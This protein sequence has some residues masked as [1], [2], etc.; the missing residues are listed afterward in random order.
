[1]SFL[2]AYGQVRGELHE[3]GLTTMAILVILLLGHSVL[4][5]ACDQV[6]RA[7]TG[8]FTSPGYPGNY[9]NEITCNYTIEVA[10]NHV[11]QLTF[12]TFILE[13]P[14]WCPYD[15][16]EIYDDTT[17]LGTFCGSDGPGA[18]TS[19]SNR[20]TVVLKTDVIVVYQGFSANYVA[21][22]PFSDCGGKLS[23][24]HGQIVS[25][26]YPGQFPDGCV[27]VW[28]ITGRVGDKIRVTFSHLDL[29]DATQCQRDSLEFRDGVQRTDTLLN[30][31][32]GTYAPP[33][34]T[35]T[36]N[37]MY[38]RFVSG[39][40]NSRTGF[41]LTWTSACLETF[42]S[43][44]GIIQSPA[45]TGGSRECVFII[46]QRSGYFVQLEFLGFH[47]GSDGDH[48]KKAFIEVRDG[49]FKGSPL[50]GQRYC[51]NKLPPVHVLPSSQNMMWIR[52]VTDG[53]DPKTGFRANYTR[54]RITCDR[55]V[56]RADRGTFTSPLYP[57][58]Y[59]DLMNCSWEI[60]AEP[61]HV[62]ELTF[63]T[64]MLEGP[65]RCPYDWVEIHDGAT[66][67]GKFCG[68]TGPNVVKSSS[69]TVTVTFRTDSSI[70]DKGFTA[71]YI[72][73][74]PFSDELTSQ[75]ELY[76]YGEDKGDNKVFVKADKARRLLLKA[77]FPVG[78]KLY[79]KLFIANRGLVSFGK[80]DY[81]KQFK[82]KKSRPMIC[83]YNTDISEPG[84]N[85][86][87]YFQLY[88]KDGEVQ[89]K[90]SSQI[91][92]FTEHKEYSSSLV[93]VVTWDHVTHVDSPNPASEQAT[94]QLALISDG[95]RSYGVVYYKRGEMNWADLRNRPLIIGFSDGQEDHEPVYSPYC[96][97]P[98]AF[99][100][101]DKIKGNTGR[102][103]M[104]LHTIGDRFSP[105]QHCSDWK[106]RNSAKKKDRLVGFSRLPD[107]PCN[108]RFLWGNWRFS[109]SRDGNNVRCFRMTVGKSRQLAPHGKECCY[110]WDWWQWSSFGQFISDPPH[111]GSATAFNPAFWSLQ[112]DY[113]REDRQ[114]H[115]VCC[116][117]TTS[118][119]YCNAFY[120]LRPVGQCSSRIPFSF[121]WTWGDP[122]IK[123]LDGG[124][125]TF[126]G[127]GEYTMITLTS[128][129]LTFTLQ[130]R[131]G[132]AETES[133]SIT[134][135]TVFT[136]FG[137]EDNGV[138]VFVGLDPN[139]NE[140]LIIYGNNSDYST[141][142][143]D[144]GDDEILVESETYTMKRSN[145]SFV[146]IFASDIQLTISIGFKSL[147]ISTGIPLQY[148]NQT[149]GL[150]GNFNGVKDDDFVLPNGTF[151]KSNLTDRE[152]Y[153]DFG[154]SWAVTADNSILR[155][156]PREGPADFAHP[157]FIPIFLDEVAMDTRQAAED[158]CGQT[159]VACIYDYVA[160][161]SAAIANASK[162]TAEMAEEREKITENTIPVLTFNG[163]MYGTSGNT[164]NFN[165]EGY[166]PDDND[167]L[168]YYV[169]DDGSGAAQINSSSGDVTL[170]VDSS[171][172]VNMRFYAV[173]SKN[174]QSPVRD[175]TLITCSGCTNH[176]TCDF[177]RTST[178][179]VTGF[180]IAA[181]DCDPAWTG[182]NCDEDYDAC[183]ESPCD[184][185]QVCTDLTPDQQGGSDVGFT[186]SGCPDG[187]HTDPEDS[188]RCIDINECSQN[189]NCTHLCVNTPGSYTC[190]CRYGYRLDS[191]D[192][193]CDDVNECAEEM[194]GCQQQCANTEGSFECLCSPGYTLSSKGS[195]EANSTIRDLC[196]SAGCDHGCTPTTDSSGSSV[197]HCFCFNGYTLDPAN[198][199]SCVDRDECSEGV[200]S[201]SCTNTQGSFACTCYTGHV[202]SSD[203]RT[204]NPCPKLRYGPECRHTCECS[205]RGLSCHPVT[206]CVCQSGWTGSQCQDDVNEC[207]ESPD[208]CGEGKR[209]VNNNGSYTCL[210][211]DG[212]T[213]NSEGVCQDVDECSEKSTLNTCEELEQ[214]HN[215]PGS[216][217]CTCIHGYTRVNGT[218]TDLDE[219]GSTSQNQCQ[220][221]CSNVPGSYTCQCRYGYRLN[222]DRASCSQVKDVCAEFEGL[223][224]DHGCSLDDGDRAFCFCRTGYVLGT[225]KESCQDE[226]E[227]ILGTS[228]CSADS[229]CINT[230]GGYACR[231][232]I[233]SKLD[234]D[235]L[236]CLPCPTGTYGE[237]CTKSCACGL[238]ASRCDVTTG[239]V[240]KS[241][242]TGERCGQD[243]NE[244]DTVQTQEECLAKNAFCVNSQ[245]GY[246]CRCA[247]GYENVGNGCQDVNE[248]ENSPCE[249]QCEN[250]PCEQQCENSPCEQQCENF[251]GS[252]RCLCYEGFSFNDT[253]GTC[254]DIDECAV[255]VTNG[256]TQRCDNT[257]G[258]Y[259]CSCNVIGY[260]LESDNVTCNASTAL[261]NR[262]DCPTEN[263]GCSEEK[264]FCNNGYQL[265]DNNT[266]E[267]MDEDLCAVMGGECEQNC[268]ESSD[269]TSIVCGC[270]DGYLLNSDQQ[271]CRECP[272][273]MYGL[274]CTQE[275]TCTSNAESCNNVDGACL[276]KAGWEGTRCES[277][278]NECVTNQHNCSDDHVICINQ[279]GGYMCGCDI[280]YTSNES[281]SCIEC[282]ANMYGTNCTQECNCTINAESCNNVDGAC[283]CKA[284][285]EGTCCESDVNECLTNQ[286]NCSDDNVIC[287][288]EVGGYSCG[289]D[290]GYTSNESQNCI[291]CLANTYGRNCTQECTC[292]S[293]AES[294]NNVDGAC[295]C[296]AGWEGT[297]CESDV[298]ECLTNHN[299][300]FDDHMICINQDGGYKCGCEIG[301]TSNDSQS[302]IECPAN[303]YGPNCTQECTCT[304]NAESCNN[305]D[306]ACVCKAG[307]EGTRCES[308]VNE[309]L[310]NHHNCSDDHVI[311]INED[312]GYSCGCEIGYTSNGPQSCMDA[313]E[314]SDIMENNCEQECINTVGSYTCGCHR[315][316]LGSGNDCR[317]LPR[318][319]MTLTL[320]IT[321]P[322]E[323]SDPDS[324]TY[325]TWTQ[326]AEDALYTKLKPEVPGLF[327]VI[328]LS[329]RRGSLVIQAE[330]VVNNETH[331]DGNSDLTLA[332]INLGQGQLTI[333][334]QTADASLTVSGLTVNS[335][336]RACD[337]YEV[338]TPC[339]PGHPCQIKDGVPA[340]RARRIVPAENRDDDAYLFVI[341]GSSVAFVLVAVLV[342]VVVCVRQKPVSIKGPGSAIEL[343]DAEPDETAL[344]DKGCMEK[345]VPM[346]IVSAVA[347]QD[348]LPDSRKNSCS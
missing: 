193:S 117:N 284:G 171:K 61:N 168:T 240:C 54:K 144:A 248:C 31:V 268:T 210:C 281:Q 338:I 25:P 33:D 86:G 151:L 37:T 97:T 341:V 79:K 209:C 339:S 66:L 172:P 156:G 112:S 170:T 303:M 154:S 192:V 164:L 324:T 180:V 300:C 99:T 305:V 317:A 12:G 227:C 114:A 74:D 283:V 167:L 24:H 261:C 95:Q 19:S 196:A 42:K 163:T 2:T 307:W 286:H 153:E 107:C 331:P 225:D 64:F 124:E 233:G 311:C 93:L 208:V 175:V 126:N 310:T 43:D 290:V 228:G 342:T 262:T 158:L 48:C 335:S 287:I 291:E 221:Q 232:P 132:L 267:R 58:N 265:A 302:C 200:C 141:A 57:N 260:V 71:N 110:T 56:L 266:C 134:N 251:P 243:I 246:E 161:G 113:Q 298:N 111:A 133:G 259:R 90:A 229:V 188:A 325:I 13:G 9:S 92:E 162:D 264:C 50:L 41:N 332:L 223:H 346:D 322:T 343:N 131:T 88:E 348:A 20:V 105:D 315:G 21:Y 239:C 45:S 194:D 28:T 296:K 195:C 271:T 323:L 140:S 308:D 4:A 38:I 27:C 189:Y 212:Y 16:V 165:L 236:T 185:H 301:Y 199:T 230:E 18:V 125:Y 36:D 46:E 181:C 178:S 183:E 32:C 143:R 40:A 328:I 179:G 5:Q 299:N 276:C 288:N 173:D 118:D 235:G 87:L 129:D 83:T 6:L 80:R 203:Q 157:E 122:H 254:V 89:R 282:P 47:L 333:G 34:V 329:L 321:P 53:S 78:N 72:A 85:S 82:L 204:C 334:N 187:F 213:D 279:D 15:T 256:C 102:L 84:N 63:D 205:G 320:P 274:N 269:G 69:N 29:E 234:N 135:A 217:Y 75:P 327:A 278:V 147:V 344:I 330:A 216:F 224:C 77:G 214:C 241:G 252:Y 292:T 184:V 263:G 275:C 55:V 306:G 8:T 60:K 340:C 67:L 218:C 94:V 295:V 52:Y 145:Q 152:I 128:D 215:V 39:L 139:T 119:R 219:C 62:I 186:C 7:D 176:G 160:T 3:R 101:M 115:D 51:G 293:N 277:D 198:N 285:W 123:T 245:G 106:K 150:L 294:C 249:Q 191:D 116:Y 255:S 280:G 59:P 238:G 14:S 312:G 257:P 23:G 237:N 109:H 44:S 120:E 270:D 68:S 177:S 220:Q 273:N 289:C 222:V 247:P 337:V 174:V 297:R 231:C 103:G 1:M 202:M 91:R 10:S 73:Y 65:G 309:C 136:A 258:S 314:C 76:P 96:N 242:W 138:R 318:V 169:V 313:D 190:A 121:S 336:T 347:S 207:E 49:G 70:S 11:I 137:A 250:S 35:S 104:W 201:Q 326:S 142:F 206:G 253:A 244:C 272:T 81:G 17:L 146:V 166:D 127:W 316:Y 30:R 149:E 100:G 148:R 197:P 304:T 155:Y 226:D 130:G 211:P 182:E 159:N 108:W 22:V 26:G 98:E 319:P 345:D